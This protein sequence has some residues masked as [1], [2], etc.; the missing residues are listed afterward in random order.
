MKYTSIMLYAAAVLTI[1][2]VGGCTDSAPSG[3]A[4]SLGSVKVNKYVAI[5]N[6]LTAGYQSNG[7][8]ESAQI[9]SFPNQI[10]QQ[11][12]ASGAQIGKF[13]Q[14]I[15][16]DPGTPDPATGKASRYE[17]IS[18]GNPIVIGPK[19]LTMGAPT[20]VTLARP[21][22]N[23]GIPGLVIASFMDET[24]FTK[25]P[26]VDA[27]LRS[28]AGFPKSVY[29]HVSVLASAP[30]TK[31][32]LVTFW[33]GNNDVLGFATSGGVSPKAPTDAAVFA[34]LYTTALTNLRALLPDAKILVAT[35]PDVRA[36]P[37]FTTIGPKMAAGIAGA[38]ALNPAI[39]GMYYQ[40]H[41]ET[42]MGTGLTSLNAA[43]DV[44]ITLTGSPY[45]TKLG[46]PTGAWYANNKKIYPALPPGIDTTKAF[47]FDPRNPW[48]DALVLDASEQATAGNALA[49]FNA[50]IKSVAASK[51]AA[52][53][54]M[55]E[56]FNGIK[57]NGIT[58]AGEKFTTEYVSGGL[59]SLD[60]VHPSSKGAAIVANEFIRVMNASF[61]MNVSYAD[62][63]KVPGIPAPLAKYANG[64]IV[65]TISFESMRSL[66]NLMGGKF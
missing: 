61:G 2:A 59:F 8:Y 10:A 56:F 51:S 12:T 31:P 57:A 44:M 34:A 3:P 6:S 16:S 64:A 17:I 18:L 45:A 21:Y 26:L 35:I 28:A 9:Y 41:G 13:E 5:G 1:A 7:W 27:T 38:K 4:P 66:V 52:V 48:P 50:T 36:I 53:V 47:G 11:L 33:L 65:P 25:N 55:N 32:D 24:N 40:K 39:T 22:D 37:F 58:F 43:G 62:V 46:M 60:G 63:S 30:A 19:G 14:P 23:L 42:G 15:W 54:D 29:G 49:S 20:N